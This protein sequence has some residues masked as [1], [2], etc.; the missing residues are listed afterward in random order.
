MEVFQKAILMSINSIKNLMADIIKNGTKNFILTSKVN[1]DTLENLF[2]QIRTQG[3]LDDHPSNA[4]EC[5]LLTSNVNA[6]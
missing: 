2:S 3:R 4:F 1:Q 6:R 5:P